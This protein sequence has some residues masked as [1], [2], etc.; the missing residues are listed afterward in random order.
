MKKIFIVLTVAVLSL[1]LLAGCAE[2]KTEIAS[3]SAKTEVETTTNKNIAEEIGYG[4]E[5]AS[6]DNDL[7]LEEMLTYAIQDEY[8]A[9][10]EYSY[11]TETIGEQNPF[12]NIITAEEKHIA[13]LEIIFETYGYTVP[14]DLSVDYLIP[15]DNV[16]ESLETGVQAEIN[17]IAMYE[18]FLEQELPDDV[19]STFEFLRDG[20]ESH[21]A[22]FQKK[23]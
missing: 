17:N 12:T 20:S 1:G 4:A 21:L 5:G 15:Q 19:R 6:A 7:T 22:A 2:E 10:G 23:L 11:I 13:E 18:K 16:T 8:L 3:Q 14:E 9:H